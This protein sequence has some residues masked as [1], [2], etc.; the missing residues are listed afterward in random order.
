MATAADK[1]RWDD[2]HAA[3]AQKNEDRL[4][5]EIELG[6][7]YGHN[8]QSQWLTSA[9]RNKLEKLRDAKDKIGDKIVELLVRVSPRGER[10]LQGV[11][12][13]WIRE[14]LTWE[15][16]VRPVNESLSVVVP[17]AYGYPD[18]Y[19]QENKMGREEEEYDED[20]ENED[21]EESDDDGSSE[22]GDVEFAVD[23]ASGRERIFKTFDEAAGFAVSLAASGRTVDLD[24][25]IW[26]VAGARA[27]GGDDAVELYNE[28]PEASVFER[29]EITVNSVGRVA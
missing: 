10:W 5:Y 1:K 3:Y 24:V 17:G 28:D 16:A 11:P 19:V 14:K 12:A 9:Q 18:G 2:L 23:D 7:K 4:A 22:P 27:Y 25:L 21:E 29:L 6:S 20:E 8:F 15:D 13:W 26:S